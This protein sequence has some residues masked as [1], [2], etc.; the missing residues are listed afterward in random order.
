MSLID[1]LRYRLRALLHAGRHAR[2]AERE[3]RFHLD[4][5]AAQRE[6]DG[7]A[8]GEAEFGARRQ[9]GNR[10][11]AAEAMRRVAGLAWLDATRQDLAFALRSMRRAPAFTIVAAATL[12]LGIGGA[13]AIDAVMDAV[14]VRP[15]PI[16]RADRVLDLEVVEPDT[17]GGR[18]AILYASVPEYLRWRTHLR[19]FSNVAASRITSTVPLG[20]HTAGRRFWSLPPNTAVR[21]TPVTSNYFG[22]LGTTPAIGHGFGPVDH[23]ETSVR[24][25]VLSYAYWQRAYGGDT[26]AIGRT[27]VLDGDSYTVSGVMPR[28]FVFPQ[29]TQIWTS[30]A[31]DIESFKTNEHTFGL[32]VIGR[33]RD[34]V[35]PAQALAE[36]R[37]RFAADTIGLHLGTLRVQAPTVRDTIVEDAATHLVIMMACV[38]VLLVIASAN[39]TNML[40][41]R[42]MARRHE[43]ALR[44]ALGAGR[45]RIVRQLI[46]EALLLAALGA[47]AGLAAAAF[48]TRFVAGE[49]ALHLPRYSL[50]A[51]DARVLLASA[52]AAAVVGIVC[53]VVPALSVS[54][55]ALETTLRSE[56]VRHSA[57][58]GRRRL[59]DTLVVG[60]VA[61][62]VVLLA[63]AGLLLQTFRHLMELQ[64]GV[65][66]DGVLTANIYP[67]FPGQDTVARVLAARRIAERLRALPNV[68][69]ASVSTTYPLGGAISF[70]T[71]RIPGRAMADSANAFSTF[72]GV[73][74]HYFTTLHIRVVRGR[75]FTAQDDARRDVVVINETLAER[76]FG[77][78]DP[79]GR[80]IA[81]P[82]YPVPLEII[83]VVEDTRSNNM[84]STAESAAYVPVVAEGAQNLSMIVRVAGGNPTAMIR[85]IQRAAEQASPGV[86][87]SDVSPLDELLRYYAATEHAYMMILV[88]FAL[89]ALL[90]TAVGLYGIISYSVAQRTR[91]IGIRIALG[92]SPNTVRRRV[93]GEGLG[94]TV[95]GVAAGGALS[96]AATRVL[97]SMLS[98]VAPGD[99][100]VLALVAALLAAVALLACWLPARRAAAV[101]PLIAIRAE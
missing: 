44:L 90:V 51:L 14:L 70:R 60:Q 64:P 42:G 41:V 76:Y 95:A 30:A 87:L 12:G 27:I 22:L 18:D 47:L 86:Q 2:D 58:R 9:L 50:V 67:G 72:A 17:S 63:G 35:T 38:A 94:L 61:M 83:G 54:R 71:L 8:P 40:L 31:P 66:A 89:A 32:D 97:R 48:V 7:A 13:T 85:T 82:D 5:E 88:G 98:G 33:L 19:S 15:L 77:P 101:D 46:T 49:P 57:G 1:S 28:H 80:R 10:T 78:A 29:D 25:A 55:D 16:V 79:I 43:I 99:P 91:E 20:E 73:D 69:D 36:L 96:V 62:S 21:V 84:L 26:N 59:R 39:V 11:A 92:A 74:P 34:G 24:M 100:T 56:A 65:T 75:A 6:H 81:Y 52:V 37:T 68:A 53:G 93:T 4:L 3:L 45:S 23:P